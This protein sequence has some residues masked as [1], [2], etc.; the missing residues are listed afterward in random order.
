MSAHVANNSGNCEWYTPPD[1][2]RAARRVMGEIDLDPASSDKAQETVQAARYFTAE[3]D[4]LVQEWEGRVWLNPPYDNVTL[5]HFVDKLMN[6]RRVV[7][8]CVLVNNATETKW[9]QRLIRQAGAACFVSG[10]IKFLDE[11]GQPTGTPLQGQM[12]LYMGDNVERFLRAFGRFGES[13]PLSM[14]VRPAPIPRRAR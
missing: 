14:P 9:G 6:S 11:S 3:H 10:R 8:W 1:V 13:R 4:G 5:S 12:I 7:E 2:L